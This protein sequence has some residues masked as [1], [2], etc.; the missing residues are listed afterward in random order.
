MMVRHPVPDELLLD[1]TVGSAGPG[2]ALLVA[3]HLSMCEASRERYGMLRAVGG[4][5]QES[6]EGQRLEGIS[7]ESVLERAASGESADGDGRPGR[8]MPQAGGRSVPLS[9]GR[10]GDIELPQPLARLAHEVADPRA[11]RRLGLGVHAA[12]LS[13]S[14][15]RARTQLLHARPGVRIFSHTHVGEEVVLILKGAFWDGGER[16]GPGDV[17]LKDSE[18][19]HAPV[20]DDAG[21]CLCLA[22]TEGPIRFVGPWGW[23]LNRLNRF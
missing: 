8:R 9:G 6:I 15:P 20:I 4:A 11:W 21:D 18:T 1:Y 7:A 19:V 12:I 3:T 22:V 5:L 16:F 2:K 23:L 17:A 14:M 13:A 10:L